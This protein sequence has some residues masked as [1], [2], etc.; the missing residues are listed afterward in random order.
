M[1]SAATDISVQNV[2]TVIVVE[3]LD[4]RLVDQAQLA[5]I[6]RQLREIIGEAEL[7]KMLI[8]FDN[9]ESLSSG[10][11]GVFIE[12]HKTIQAKD[13]KLCLSNVD[14]ELKKLFTMTKL[15]RVMTICKSNERAM[16]ELEG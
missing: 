12:L 10:A 16:R 8:D 1:T 9:V 15:H 14:K 6:G 13:G 11:L 7:P 2:G 4:R 3:F 5:R